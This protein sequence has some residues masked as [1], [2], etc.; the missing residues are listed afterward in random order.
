LDWAV[1]PVGR[2]FKPRNSQ[3]GEAFDEA[4]ATLLAPRLL[5]CA[6]ILEIHRPV[7]ADRIA[8]AKATWLAVETATYPRSANIAGVFA[9]PI[10]RIAAK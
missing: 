8:R 3:G 6:S 2:Q 4:A 5:E 7:L 9:G 1:G 10:G